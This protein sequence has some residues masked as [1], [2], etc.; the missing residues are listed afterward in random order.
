[1]A[2]MVC[3]PHDLSPDTQNL[4]KAR[5]T[6]VLMGKWEAEMGKVP[7]TS[8]DYA[9]MDNKRL[10]GGQGSTRHQRLSYNMYTM[11]HMYSHTQTYNS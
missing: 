2:E 1:M 6:V 4:C 3:E 7:E 5:S 10:R 9:V 11:V 8:L